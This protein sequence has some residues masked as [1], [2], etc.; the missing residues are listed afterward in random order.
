M[1]SEPTDQRVASDD[2]K[3]DGALE[4]T[5]SLSQFLVVVTWNA[6]EG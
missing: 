6:V 3:V 1:T 5:V 4:E 2:E